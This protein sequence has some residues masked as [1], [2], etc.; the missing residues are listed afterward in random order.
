MSSFSIPY[1]W[2]LVPIASVFALFMALYFFKDMM[3]KEE[4]TPR[5]KEIAEYIREGSFAYL[6]QQYKT[7][8]LVFI[9][10]FFVFVVLA[11]MGIQNVFVPVAFLTGGLF[12]GLCGFLGMK[13]ATFASARTANGAR[14]SLNQGL[15]TAFRAGA[16]MGLVV[17]GFG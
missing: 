3:K 17:V 14:V 4:G 9:V 7:V 2:Y 8:S 11:L 13:T 10:L 16:V 12:S 5:M 1:Y 6:S 15:V